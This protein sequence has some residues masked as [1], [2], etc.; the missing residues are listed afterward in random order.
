MC[1]N[2]FISQYTVHYIASHVHMQISYSLISQNTK[3]PDPAPNYHLWPISRR[4]QPVLY[5]KIG[6]IEFD[7]WDIIAYLD[8]VAVASWYANE[9]FPGLLY[10]KTLKLC[11][12]RHALAVFDHSLMRNFACISSSDYILPYNSICSDV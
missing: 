3:V 5:A 6:R 9:V 12:L 2:S 11:Q 4:N 1:D 7:I 8:M 10:C